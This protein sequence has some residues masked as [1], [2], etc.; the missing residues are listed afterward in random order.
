MKLMI[1]GIALLC[2]GSCCGTFAD[3]AWGPAGCPPVGGIA[4]GQVQPQALQWFKYDNRPGAVYLYRGNTMVG[5]YTYGDGFYREPYYGA[6][7]APKKAPL[8]PPLIGAVEDQAGDPF[9]VDLKQI[10]NRQVFSHNGIEVDRDDVEEAIGANLRDDSHG[11]HVTYIDRDA[12]RRARVSETFQRLRSQGKVPEH[13]RFQAYD[14]A[15]LQSRHMLAVNKLDQDQ[16]FQSTGNELLAQVADKDAKGKSKADQ[17]FGDIGEA[18]LVQAV[19]K[20]CPDWIDPRPHLPA[21]P[22]LFHIPWDGVLAVLALAVVGVVL[23]KTAQ[24]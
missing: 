20:A 9:G 11:G 7:S 12:G 23:V 2:C 14:P 21:L 16:K 19:R 6:W 18:E 4:L 8:A 13:V 3:A 17:W 1:I 10:G 5:V 22:D 15:L 24:H